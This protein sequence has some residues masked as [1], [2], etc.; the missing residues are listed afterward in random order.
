MAA[1]AQQPVSIVMD[2][3]D[4]FQSYRC[5]AV[6]CC[7]VLCHDVHHTAVD[8]TLALNQLNDGQVAVRMHH[9]TNT[10]HIRCIVAAHECA[11]EAFTSLR[12]AATILET[13]TMP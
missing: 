9:A 13:Q 4:S 10:I 12:G 5:A 1:V 11:A 8:C 6:L 7:A 3:E 2:V